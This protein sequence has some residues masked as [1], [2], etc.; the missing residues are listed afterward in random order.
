MRRLAALGFS[1]LD[2]GSVY[3]QLRQLERD[4][5]V[6]SG[7]DTSRDGPARRLSTLAD[8]GRA[9]LD[10][11][12]VA[13]RSQQVLI[14]QFLSRLPASRRTTPDPESGGPSPARLR[15]GDMTDSHGQDPPA[16]P[17]TRLLDG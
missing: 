16:D 7:W 9:Y 8:L 10:S 12:A 4:G 17:W 6:V 14:E 13:M 1:G 2:R 15:G 3:R 5:D 11:C